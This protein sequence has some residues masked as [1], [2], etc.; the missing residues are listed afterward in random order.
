MATRLIDPSKL[1]VFGAV[2]DWA[3]PPTD[4]SRNAIGARADLAADPHRAGIVAEHAK[5]RAT[6]PAATHLRWML[7]PTH[8]YP[9]RPFTVWRRKAGT[10]STLHPIGFSTVEFFSQHWVALDE[11]VGFVEAT[12]V[13]T[14]PGHV[15]ATLGTP[16]ISTEVAKAAYPAGPSTVALSGV[17]LAA[18]S[19]T[20]GV[21]VTAVRGSDHTEANDSAWKEVEVVG[22]PSDHRMNTVFDLGDKQGLVG[23]LGPA[24]DA[25]LDRYRR[26]APMAGWP[27]MLDVTR[28]APPWTLA[29][30]SAIV[31]VFQTDMLEPLIT[32]FNLFPAS[33]QH[34]YFEKRTLSAPGASGTTQPV[35]AQ[36][37]PLP[38]MLFGAAT[39]PLTALITGFGTAYP[40]EPGEEHVGRDKQP[41]SAY[42]YMVTAEYSQGAGGHPGPVEYAAIVFAPGPPVPPSAP[43]NLTTRADGL[44]RAV[45]PD[46]QWTAITRVDWDRPPDSVAYRL[47]SYALARSGDAPATAPV[48]LMDQRPLD[49]ALQPIGYSG[50]TS[51]TAVTLSSALDARYTVDSTIN[52][53]RLTYGLTHQDI[54]GLWSA[55]STVA[56]TVAEPPADYV[57]LQGAQ[58]VATA[59]PG[60]ACPATLTIDCAWDWTTRTPD[61]LEFVGRLFNTTR[62]D[63]QPADVSVP[64]D[65]AYSS[66]GPTP[67]VPLTMQFATDGKATLTGLPAAVTGKVDYLRADG[68]GFGPTAPQL[69]GPRRYRITLTGLSLDFASSGFVGVA[70]FARGVELLAPNRVGE[71]T[72]R[73][74]VTA[75]ADPRP[76][77]IAIE[78]EN[79]LLASVADAV[80]VHHAQISWPAS[81]GAVGYFVYTS[82]ESTFRSR[83]GLGE[84]TLDRTLA[85]RLVDLRQLFAADTGR[86]SFTRINST[87]TPATSMSVT[88]PRG[89]K[90]IHLYVVLGVSAGQVESAWPS[91]SDPL[92]RKRPIAFAAPQLTR[93]SP[94]TL[95]VRRGDSST[96]W[97]GR[98]AVNATAGA[99]VS[100]IDLHRVRNGDAATNL[101][102][103]GPPIATITGSGGGW[104]VNSG[105][106]DGTLFPVAT[107]TG[108]DHPTGSWNDVYYRAV[109]WTADD[110]TRGIYG[111]RSLPSASRRVLIPPPGPPDLGP[112]L[113]DIATAQQVELRATTLTPVRATSLGSHLVQLVVNEFDAV[114][115]PSRLF[116]VTVTDAVSY[117]LDELP[118]AAPVAPAV[119]V[120]CQ[121]GATTA[122]PA[123]VRLAVTRSDPARP[124]SVRV[125]LTDP[126]GRLTEQTL[127]IPPGV[128]V[129]APD[130]FGVRSL[131][132]T[133]TTSLL[134]FRTTAPDSVPGHG[135]FTLI[136]TLTRPRNNPFIPPLVRQVVVDLGDIAPLVPGEDLFADPATIQ[137]RQDRDVGS[138]E[139]IAAIRGRWA[140]HVQ[141]DGP[142][143]RSADFSRSTP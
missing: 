103:M 56:H 142:D 33:F 79:V 122:D 61:R 111:G 114:G 42:D 118:S 119:S 109:A 127:D 3:R 45:T 55:W 15:T 47:G 27:S 99:V 50:V 35:Q 12:I 86:S 128:P 62:L 104:T 87:P 70:L 5:Q 43:A 141:L 102:M 77:V 41:R 120:W 2:F 67:G 38:T 9:T 110:P 90:E 72:L 101:D 7:N 14:A 60:T 88:L 21:T 13:A 82:S 112:I 40:L 6:L 29:D 73:P 124:L 48:P 65:F 66:T 63:G 11:V 37:R 28:A 143:G 129:P 132:V 106:L 24:P 81:T 20:T 74:L 64:T 57:T 53:N 100:R 113:A 121:R 22:L 131:A 80:G 107:V 44:Q 85:Q 4:P 89:S 49:V 16:G 93:P 135:P 136:I 69:A 83:R 116:P 91:T 84:P 19:F 96:G 31:K 138:R 95:E 123:T 52:P 18:L 98:V 46:Q 59:V 17:A 39:D 78:H 97:F 92:A 94:P 125:R 139:V 32:A 8:G 34:T 10:P 58:L 23:L 115:K 134:G 1:V 108:E 54:W 130:L 133:P 51:P 36:F 26:G 75:A 140:V 105:Q 126:L 71:W 25:A 30:P 68:S 117:K 137:L 76:P